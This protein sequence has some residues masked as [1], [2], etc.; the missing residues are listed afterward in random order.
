MHLTQH[1]RFIRHIDVVAGSR[2][3]Q[4]A[5]IRDGR[6]QVRMPRP[7]ADSLPQRLTARQSDQDVTEDFIPLL[8]VYATI[9]P[10]ISSKSS[11]TRF[12]RAAMSDAS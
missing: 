10:R 2:P 11:C 3:F 7:P 5:G 4:L 6:L 8:M 9:A 1:A 12:S